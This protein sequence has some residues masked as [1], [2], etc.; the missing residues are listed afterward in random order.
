MPIKLIL[1]FC[2]LF[3]FQNSDAQL[4]TQKNVGVNAGVVFALG[5]RFDRVGISVSA[6]YSENFF[7]MNSDLRYYFNF[8][9]LGPQKKYGEAVA[10]LGVVF[11]FGKMNSDTNLFLSSVSNQT[12]Y[13]NS[14]AYSYNCY[15]NKI[16]TTQQTGI[17]GLQ[18]D[19]FSLLIENDIFARPRFDRF[20]TGAVLLQ[21]Q[22][23]QFQYGINSTLWTGQ[24]GNRVADSSAH[25]PYGYMDT[26]G[27]VYPNYSHGLLSAQLKVVLPYSQ[28]AQVNAG[29]DAEQV[30]DAIQNRFIHDVFRNKNAP[31]PMLDTYGLP[32]LYHK[33]QKIRPARFYYNAFL[34]PGVF[35]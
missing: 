25:L 8:R 26:T 32:Y 29:V 13:K 6:Y 4:Y 20:R 16:K 22:D 19:H 27:G 30:R 21:Y 33:G 15:F 2:F 17:V 23:K 14:F 9:N 7:Q 5:N 1:I 34:D 24:M 28:F 12:H 31:I 3:L 11:G 35:Y 18:Y 10:S